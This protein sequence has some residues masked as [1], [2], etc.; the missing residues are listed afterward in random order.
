VSDEV[1]VPF[2]S[3]ART[4]RRRAANA[5]GGGGGGAEPS[6]K[7]KAAEGRQE[8]AGAEEDGGAWAGRGIGQEGGR[9]LA[10]DGAAQPAQANQEKQTKPP[11]ACLRALPGGK[12]T[13]LEQLS[14]AG[15]GRLLGEIGLGKYVPLFERVPVDGRM[16][17]ECTD[18]AL[19]GVGVALGAHRRKLME[20]VRRLREAAEAAGA[21]EAVEAEN[22]A[23]DVADAADAVEE[24]Q[25][26]EPTAAAEEDAGAAEGVA[27]AAA[28]P[29]T[30]QAAVTSMAGDVAKSKPK[31]KARP[32][33]TGAAE[34]V[35]RV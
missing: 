19:K 1:V 17:C 24:K 30:A 8:E 20:N 5:G 29:Q 21:A 32:R 11:R 25:A 26:V 16:L 27:G 10:A 12:P 14:A 33:P 23:A 18:E 2:G 35:P 3:Q 15:V 28:V 9:E 6:A 13:P 4:S 7:A 34:R 22:D 31:A